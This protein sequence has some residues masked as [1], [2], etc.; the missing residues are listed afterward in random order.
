MA[1][2][3]KVVLVASGLIATLFVCFIGIEVVRA[4]RDKAVGIGIIP[5]TLTRPA[6]IGIAVAVLFCACYWRMRTAH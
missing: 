6:F 3:I 2:T 5:L 1:S 4:G